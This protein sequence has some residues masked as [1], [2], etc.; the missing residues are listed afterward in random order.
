MVHPAFGGDIGLS[1]DWTG[2][3]ARSNMRPILH[4]RARPINVFDWLKHFENHAISAYIKIEI[5]FCYAIILRFMS[6]LDENILR[7]V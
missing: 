1:M 5:H 2:L 4:P 7:Y 3:V 6:F